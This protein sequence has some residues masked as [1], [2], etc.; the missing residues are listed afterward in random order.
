[1]I[2]YEIGRNPKA[3]LTS[4]ARSSMANVELYGSQGDASDKPFSMLVTPVSDTSTN[5]ISDMLRK[6]CAVIPH[7]VLASLSQQLP[8]PWH[9]DLHLGNIFISPEG[10]V[11]CLIDWQDCA[12]L[13][14]FL[15]A[16]VPQFIQ[17]DAEDLGV[18][19]PKD[20]SDKPEGEQIDILETLKSCLTR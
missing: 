20:L 12:V 6:L 4:T 15:A 14:L 17:L 18:E 5:A 7:L 2:A 8:V 16:R 9:K 19:L 1:M 13:P 3:Y 10:K 11:S